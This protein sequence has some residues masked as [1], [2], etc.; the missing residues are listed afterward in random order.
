MPMPFSMP[1]TLE[2]KFLKTKTMT[3]LRKGP[4]ICIILKTGIKYGKRGKDKLVSFFASTKRSLA[5]NAEPLDEK[6]EIQWQMLRPLRR[7]TVQHRSH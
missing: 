4:D 6:R 5:A 2:G 7:L 1:I 3:Y